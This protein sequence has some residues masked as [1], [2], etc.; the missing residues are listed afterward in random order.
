MLLLVFGNFI[1][2]A[3]RCGS[4]FLLVMVGFV[5]FFVV[6]GYQGAEE[7]LEKLLLTD[8]LHG[9]ELAGAQVVCVGQPILIVG[10]VAGDAV[11]GESIRFLL[12][13]ALK[14]RRRNRRR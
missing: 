11:D 1:G 7:D 6:Y 12:W 10:D 5:T 8:R 9:A 4:L 2:L 14:L 3:E 13:G